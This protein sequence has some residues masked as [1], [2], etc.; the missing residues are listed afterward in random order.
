MAAT[1]KG[2][3]PGM[4]YR[5]A[6]N[7]YVTTEDGQRCSVVEVPSGAFEVLVQIAL[8]TISNES[9]R[10]AAVKAIEGLDYA[11]KAGLID[12]WYAKAELSERGAAIPLFGPSQEP[13]PGGHP[14]KEGGGE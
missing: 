4:S 8:T 14:E 6:I 3:D 10:A 9:D 12:R 2:L 7:L 11:G 13:A 1:R 5:R